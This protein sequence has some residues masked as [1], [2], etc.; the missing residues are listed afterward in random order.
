MITKINLTE[1]V[2][3]GQL[4]DYS[5]K[6]ELN[7][8]PQD[9]EMCAKVELKIAIVN[10]NQEP[11]EGYRSLRFSS[12]AQLKGFIMN[13]IK[14]YA[15]FCKQNKEINPNNFNYKKD[16]FLKDSLRAFRGE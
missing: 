3:L 8:L 6:Y 7:Y 15:L 4:R 2:V 14:A 13:L 1:A 10:A 9:N 16:M 11:L 12:S 5:Q